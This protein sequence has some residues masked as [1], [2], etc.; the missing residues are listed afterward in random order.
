MKRRDRTLARTI[1][2]GPSRSESGSGFHHGGLVM[3][4]KGAPFW[5]PEDPY[6]APSRSVCQSGL[7]DN[8][9]VGYFDDWEIRAYREFFDDW[10]VRPNWDFVFCQLGGPSRLGLFLTSG[11]FRLSF[12]VSRFSCLVSCFSCLDSCFSFL[13]FGNFESVGQGKRLCQSDF[14]IL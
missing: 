14:R 7:R 13:V 9:P 10:E 12:L 1:G 6:L 2:S 11:M 3:D 5:T 4:Q 8:R